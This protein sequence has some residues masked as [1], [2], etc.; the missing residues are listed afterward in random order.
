MK[1][2]P[3]DPRD[4]TWEID[5]PKYRVYFWNDRY[6][7][8]DEYEISDASVFDTIEWAKSTSAGRVWELWLVLHSDQGAGQAR[9]AFVDLPDES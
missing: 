9:L 2:D 8:C 5:N 3:V 4:I 6:S 7:A 1:V